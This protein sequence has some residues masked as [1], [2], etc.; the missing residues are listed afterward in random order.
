MTS[1][2]DL[3]NRALDSITAENIG[4]LSQNTKPAIL[5]N[6]WYDPLRRALLRAAP[7][8][9]AER[10]TT[11]TL[12]GDVTDGGNIQPWVFKYLYP[13]QCLKLRYLLPTPIIQTGV[14]D[15]I[16][17]SDSW[18]QPFGSYRGSPFKIANELNGSA[19]RRVVCT[20]L[21]DAVGVYVVDEET[22]DIFD[23]TFVEALVAALASKLAMPMASDKGLEQQKLAI[24]NDVIMQA[25]AQSANESMPTTD[26]T[27]DWILARGYSQI[28]Y[29]GFGSWG[30]GCYYGW[31][32][33]SWAM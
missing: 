28:N 5:C 12:L 11:L 25:R 7:W 10:Q 17:L 21:I 14:V 29:G 32:D 23:Q 8:G 2:V 26:H 1:S 9:F 16:P 3:C 22:V 15:P 18:G 24:A 30:P 31:D 4:S 19:A 13:A 20:N 6:R 33:M 27:P